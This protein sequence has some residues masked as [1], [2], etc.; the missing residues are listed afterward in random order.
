MTELATVRE[1]AGAALASLEANRRRIDDLNVYPVPD[2][3]TGTNLH[4]TLAAAVEA[5][6]ESSLRGGDTETPTPQRLVSALAHGALMGARG[7]SGVIL[8]QLLRGIADGLE[9]VEGARHVGA[10]VA[11]GHR[12]DVEAV[13]VGGVGP[14]HVA[15]G[16]HRFAQRVDVEQ[17]QR[18]HAARLKR[19]CH[20]LARPVRAAM[21]PITCWGKLFRWLRGREQWRQ[22]CQERTRIMASVCE[23]CGKKPSWGMS[24]SHSH[25]RTKRRWNPN[26]QRVRA[27]VSGS[28]KRVNVCT[29]CLK[30]GKIAKAS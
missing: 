25:R 15:E 5:L 24:V 14:H 29:G 23:V 17:L 9:G 16:G 1:L 20:Q 7:N 2:G 21:R 22:R 30:S 12:V 4:L 10:G 27:T 18:W 19:G 11:V 8:A 26:I 28:V 13:D 6:A 3:D